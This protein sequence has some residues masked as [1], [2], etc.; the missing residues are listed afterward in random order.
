MKQRPLD[1]IQ[2]LL[3]QQPLL[4]NHMV[5]TTPPLRMALGKY[6]DT[7]KFVALCDVPGMMKP[8]GHATAK[9]GF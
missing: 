9:C 4:F 8:S 6:R 1:S 3:Q 5:S 2:L 7:N